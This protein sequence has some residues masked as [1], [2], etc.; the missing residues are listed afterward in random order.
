MGRFMEIWNRYFVVFSKDGLSPFLDRYYVQ[1]L[2]TN[3]NVNVL[4]EDNTKVSVIIKGIDEHGFLIAVDKDGN[5][6]E[7]IPDGNTFNFLEGLISKK[8]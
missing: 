7:L 8:L 3:Q 1:W 4:R 5:Q 2:H 6:L